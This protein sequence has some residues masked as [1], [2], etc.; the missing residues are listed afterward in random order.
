MVLAGAGRHEQAERP[1]VEPDEADPERRRRALDARRRSCGRLPEHLVDPLDEPLVA[2]RLGRLGQAGPH[3]EHVVVRRRRSRRSSSSRA[4][5]LAQLPLDPVA[6]T[7]LVAGRLRHGEAEP[8]LARLA[9]RARTSRGSGSASRPTGR[10]GRRRRSR[11]SG[12]DGSCAAR[13]P[14]PRGACG[15]LARRR[16]RIGAARR[17]S[18]SGAEAVLPLPPAH[19]WLI[20]PLHRS[21][22]ELRGRARGQPNG[23][24]RRTGRR[25]AVV[26][27]PVGGRKSRG[28][29]GRRST[30]SET[31]ST[32]VESRCGES[33]IPAKQ[34]RFT[35]AR[36]S[37]NPH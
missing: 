10:A 17:A 11:G 28:K 16:L 31:L 6:R 9:R 5:D 26:H 36:R 13:R 33:F 2:A 20:G 14:T 1:A 7:T 24:Y 25:R 30:V 37:R 32:A 21:R 22:T 23:Q 35:S 4:P 8:R 29:C 15:P 3:D 12:R 27:R 34:R 19:V 18:P